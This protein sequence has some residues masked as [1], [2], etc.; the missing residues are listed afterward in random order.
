MKRFNSLDDF[1]KNNFVE[2]LRDKLGNEETFNLLLSYG[3][4]LEELFRINNDLLTSIS[5]YIIL[6]SILL[7]YSMNS[8]C[9]F[10]SKNSHGW[11]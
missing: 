9:S 8:G 10:R 6:T 11:K 5:L 1:I 7:K 2:I 4:H 3:T